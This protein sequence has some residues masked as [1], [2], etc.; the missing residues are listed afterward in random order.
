MSFKDLFLRR[1]I[2]WGRV[3][4]K[5]YKIRIIH[6]PPSRLTRVQ[7]LWARYPTHVVTESDLWMSA[8]LSHS[9]SSLEVFLQCC[10]MQAGFLFSNGLMG[11]FPGGVSLPLIDSRSHTAEEH[12]GAVRFCCCCLIACSSVEGGQCVFLQGWQGYFML[13][14]LLYYTKNL[15]SLK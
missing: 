2:F 11:K 6:Y 1:D 5:E 8:L 15:N 3:S 13:L 4:E 9:C 7:E 10:I 14:L 12:Q